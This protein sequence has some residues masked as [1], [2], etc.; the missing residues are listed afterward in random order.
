MSSFRPAPLPA[1]DRRRGEV[2][3]DVIRSRLLTGQWMAGENIS[4]EELKNELGVS[5]QPVMDAL[6]RLS[7][8]GLVDVLPQVGC[9]V[10]AYQPREAADFFRLFA[11]SESEAAAMAVGRVTPLQLAYLEDINARIA[12]VF[13]APP[14]QRAKDYMAL[15]REF[16]GAIRDMTR[17][18]LIA[19]TSSQ[20][21]DLSDLLIA[22]AREQNPL[23]EEVRERYGDHARIIDAIRSGNEDA[24]R[25]EIHEH[26]LRNAAMLGL[27]EA[28]TGEPTLDVTH[29]EEPR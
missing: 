23:A 6:R 5:K 7:A 15:N 4:I 9:R 12:A 8:A 10:S 19:H 26:I 3:Y 13:D 11:A 24:V 16:H 14:Q 29:A 17:S 1:G 25:R 22:T 27:G 20:L 2:V 21:W 28:P 18:S